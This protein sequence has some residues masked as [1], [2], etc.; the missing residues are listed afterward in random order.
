MSPEHLQTLQTWLPLANGIASIAFLAVILTATSLW[1]AIWR[2]AVYAAITFTF[3]AL[4]MPM[5]DYGSWKLEALIGTI[6][7]G[8]I[9]Y[10][11]KKLVLTIIRK[12]SSLQS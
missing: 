7:M 9:L 11:L 4:V 6:V 1:Q 5:P 10:G 3:V 2:S 12:I 8:A